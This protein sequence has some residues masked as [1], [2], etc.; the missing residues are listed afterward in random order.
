MT[1]IFA[2]MITVYKT[3]TNKGNLLVYLSTC[4]LVY[5]STRLLVNLLC[6]YLHTCVDKSCACN[7]LVVCYNNFCVLCHLS[8]VFVCVC[9]NV[10]AY[11]LKQDFVSFQMASD[12]A[13]LL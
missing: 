6:T 3:K 9:L 5:L 8:S 13:V 4:Q 7:V 12:E 1:G 11:R 10:A 2:L